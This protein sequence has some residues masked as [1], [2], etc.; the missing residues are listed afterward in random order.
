MTATDPPSTASDDQRAVYRIGAVARLTGISPNTLRIWERRYD[1]VDPQRTAKGGRLYSKQ[2]IARLALIK[3]L[4]DQGDSISTVANLALETL[5]QRMQ[6]RRQLVP[7]PIVST[8][9]R[10]VCIVGGALAVRVRQAP[11]IPEVVTLVGI[12]ES[13]QAYQQVLPV[14][15]SLV[16]EVPALDLAQLDLLLGVSRSGRAE[17]LVIVYAFANQATRKAAREHGIELLRAPLPLDQLWRQCVVAVAPDTAPRA[18]GDP[19]HQPVATRRFSDVQLAHFATTSTRIKCEC[20][21]HLADIIQTLVAFEDYSQQ[22]QNRNQDDAAL[23]AY[24]LVTTARAR[25]ILEQS[26]AKVAEIENIRY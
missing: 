22:C 1:L 6:D 12:F 4:V 20:P 26:L 11:A 19:E 9:P 23:H 14:C 5:R 21:Q 3:G 7:A 16:I 17:S 15:Q 24:L 10:S 13:L 25:A 2:D 18:D 8:Q